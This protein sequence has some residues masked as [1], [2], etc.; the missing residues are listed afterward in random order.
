MSELIDLQEH[1][2]RLSFLIAELPGRSRRNLSWL[3]AADW[4][5]TAAGVQKVEIDTSRF[6]ETVMWCGPAWDYESKRSELLTQVGT[7]L[8]VFN[9]V[10]GGFETVIK[11]IAPPCVPRHIKRRRTVIDDALFY[12]KNEYEPTPRVALYDDVLAE[13]RLILK[14]YPHYDLDGEFKEHSFSGMSGLGAHI[15]RIIRNDF[16]HGSARLPIPHDW[17]SDKILDSERPY[18]ELIGIS[19]R[20]LLLTAQ[21]LLLA[22]LKDE[23]IKICNL[24]DSDGEYYDTNAQT[25]LRILHLDIHSPNQDQLPL[26]EGELEYG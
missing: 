23:K 1:C 13:L 26:F 18:P 21:M 20:I 12:L 8:T 5:N 25:A 19:S 22:H 11:V 6:D 4:L 3:S 16:A 9:F 17:G 2:Y 24:R 14:E 7:Q 15:V 10:W